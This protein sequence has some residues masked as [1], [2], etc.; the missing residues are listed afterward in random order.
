MLSG[1]A[2]GFLVWPWARRIKQLAMSSSSSVLSLNSAEVVLEAVG[3]STPPPELSSV[4]VLEEVAGMAGS[5]SGDGSLWRLVR[6]P[7]MIICVWSLL[8][9]VTGSSMASMVYVSSVSSKRERERERNRE[10]EREREREM[11]MK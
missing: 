6:L 1:E 7:L 11:E 5:R 10:R 9:K 4:L 3:M 2:M 8:D